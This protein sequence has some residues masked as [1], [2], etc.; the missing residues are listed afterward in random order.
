M[1]CVYHLFLHVDDIYEIQLRRSQW[2]ARSF[3]RLEKKVARRR[4]AMECRAMFAA[5]ASTSRLKEAADT[6]ST[7]SPSFTRFTLVAIN[8]VVKH[9]CL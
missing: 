7:E 5:L 6:V 8:G 2:D 3:P 4:E 9:V 1:Y